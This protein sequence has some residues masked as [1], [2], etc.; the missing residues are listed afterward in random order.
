V[1]PERGPG[2][3]GGAPYGEAVQPCPLQQPKT[4]IAVQLIGEDDK[5]VPGI[6]YRI[7]LPD[8]STREGVLDAEGTARVENID[9]GTCV[10]TFPGLDQDAWEGVS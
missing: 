6:P 5:P 1:T 4:W 3:A 10:V 2:V 7:L 9:P 8:G